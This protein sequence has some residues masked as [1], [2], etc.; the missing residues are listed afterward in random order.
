LPIFILIRQLVQPAGEKSGVLITKKV[1]SA[2]WPVI[3]RSVELDLG[4]ILSAGAA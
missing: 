3:L 1:T 4:K 2:R